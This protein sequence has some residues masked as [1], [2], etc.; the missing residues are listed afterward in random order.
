MA[1]NPN[2]QLLEEALVHQAKELGSALLADG[3]KALGG[4]ENDGCMCAEMMPVN[5][6]ILTFAGTALTVETDNGDNFPIH[7]ATYSG[8]DGYV[9]VVDG[10]GNKERAYL[11]GLI[12]GAAKA[13]GFRAIVCDGYVRDRDDCTT[14]GMPVF[15]TGI[16]QRGPI[17]KDKG[18]IN[19]PLQCGGI[20]VFPGDLVVGDCDGVSVV[21]REKIAEVIEK[22][23]EK[24]DYEVK[25]VATI[26]AYEEDRKKGE[27]LPELAPQWVLDMLSGQ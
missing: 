13:I 23:R 12:A 5:T 15:A 1:Y 7:V 6:E 21:P 8:G 2:P 10:K 16:M 24:R 4:I 17:K 18:N 20:T 14:E 19:I 9:M 27:P 11:G 25:R 22:A 26:H 3:M